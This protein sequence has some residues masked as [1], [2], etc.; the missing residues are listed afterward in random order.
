MLDDEHEKCFT[1]WRDRMYTLLFKGKAFQTSDKVLRFVLIIF[2]L[3][4]VLSVMIETVDF[5]D[6]QQNYDRRVYT[7]F[8]DIGAW[9]IFTTELL[10]RVWVSDIDLG[11]PISPSASHIAHVESPCLAALARA[12][13]FSI[14]PRL[15]VLLWPTVLFD[16]QALVPTLI[17]FTGAVDIY[18]DSTAAYWIRVWRA[19]RIVK[20]ARYMPGMKILFHVLRL[21]SEDLITGFAF[22]ASLVLTMSFFIFAFEHPGNP[23]QFPDLI[24]TLWYGIVTVTTVGYGDLTP[25]TP[26]GR[27]LGALTAIA[28]SSFF[29][30]PAAIIGTGFLEI[31]EKQA[32]VRRQLLEKLF[33]YKK[34]FVLQSTLL[35]LRNQARLETQA[36]EAWLA[37]HE[38]ELESQIVQWQNGAA[39][40]G[41]AAGDDG[42]GRTDDVWRRRRSG[43]LDQVAGGA[44]GGVNDSDTQLVEASTLDD[45]P[46]DDR[47]AG[48][49]SAAS[50]RRGDPAV[51]DDEVGAVGRRRRPSHGPPIAH[52]NSVARGGTD[53]SRDR[54]RGSGAG[55]P[56]SGGRSSAPPS[57][58]ARTSGPSSFGTS[59]ASGAPASSPRPSL[60]GFFLQAALEGVP[61]VEGADALD[62]AGRIEERRRPRR[63]APLHPDTSAVAAGAD[64][65]GTVVR[66]TPSHP[67]NASNAPGAPANVHPAGLPALPSLS[68]MPVDVAEWPPASLRRVEDLLRRQ[69]VGLRS[70]LP[71]F[72]LRSGLGVGG[73]GA[74]APGPGGG[75][76][77]AAGFAESFARNAYMAVQSA[78]ALS[79]ARALLQRSEGSLEIAMAALLEVTALQGAA[80]T[81]GGAMRTVPS[82]VL[83]R[84]P[85]GGP[86]PVGAG[87]I[88]MAGMK[89]IQS[90]AAMRA[91]NRLPAFAEGFAS[92]T[93]GLTRAADDTTPIPST[94]DRASPPVVAAHAGRVEGPSG[95]REMGGDAI[96]RPPPADAFAAGPPLR[97]T[98]PASDTLDGLLAATEVPNSEIL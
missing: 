79:A 48:G 33:A 55:L 5:G 83:G 74:G 26:V 91:M 86:V 58:R 23:E 93:V 47:L 64:S 40:A 84:D 52:S 71:S 25:I 76:A 69:G 97:P 42:G 81:A 62:P 95:R 96:R 39:T 13:H 90:V 51:S 61:S 4:S 59:G 17:F 53:G 24:S 8:A 19:F 32:Q 37:D 28:G 75:V 45:A 63:S 67:A 85:R 49:R 27:I 56:P 1:D 11:F 46:S 82:F 36:I 43:P 50:L 92:G 15:R 3:V 80:P 14:A 77:G 38:A 98:P 41:A 16:I 94:L 2:V 21:K 89:R 29:T 54:A 9:A 6:E 18:G 65:M 73:T 57:P 31:R 68:T 12:W 78:T 87:A 34:R 22:S 72:S 30:L 88:A 44:A 35:H 7:M 66:G 60:G 70:T 10:C 20:Y